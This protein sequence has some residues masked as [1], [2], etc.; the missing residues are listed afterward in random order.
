ML[1][2]LHFAYNV[3]LLANYLNS[4]YLHLIQWHQRPHLLVSRWTGRRQKSK[5]W[6]A[7]RM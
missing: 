4:S 5:L 2:G 6:A 3:A 1:F 7:G